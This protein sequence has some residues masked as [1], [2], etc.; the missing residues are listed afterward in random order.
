GL[1]TITLTGNSSNGCST[2]VKAMVDAFALPVFN[3]TPDTTTCRGQQFTL[4]ASGAARYAWTPAATLNCDT[5]ANTIANPI[6][7]TSYILTGTSAQGCVKKDT[8]DILVKQPFTIQYTQPDKL[9]AGKNKQL[10][11]SG[12]HQYQWWPANGLS[13]PLIANPVAQPDSTTTY[14]VVGTDDKGCFKDTGFV[15]LTVYPIPKVEAGTDKTITVGMPVDL[16]AVITTDVT[17][18]NWTPTSGI[19]RNSFTGFTAKPD[20]NTEYTVEVKNKGGCSARDRITVF[21]T[22]NG[23]NVFVPNLFSPNDDG[24]NDVFYPRGVGL[25]K[26]KSMRIFNRWGEPVF[27]K[28]SFNANDPG[29]GWDGRY[30]GSKLNTDVF[31]YNIELICNNNSVLALNGNISLVR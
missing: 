9:C 26:I 10:T 23:T 6:N 16:D 13:N 25:F 19:F 18:V 28:S 21:V 20:Q 31:V 4:R 15:K 12:A 30:K 29:S 3:N 5:C 11:A 8:I 22:C 1:H 7:N 14:R 2:I 17:E 24:V 27:E